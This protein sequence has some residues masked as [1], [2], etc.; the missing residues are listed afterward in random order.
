M[1]TEQSP[2]TNVDFKQIILDLRRDLLVTFPEL[3]DNLHSDLASC[4]TDEQ[5][6]QNIYEHC[7]AIFPERFFDIL[8]QNNDIWSDNEINTTF[9]P[10]LDFAN[11]MIDENVTEQTRATV[12]KYLQLILLSITSSLNTGESFGDTAKLFEAINEDEF[13]KKLEDT[14]NQMHDMFENVTNTDESETSDTDN[15]SDDR[16]GPKINLDNLP[17]PEELHSHITGML[18]GKLGRLAR[19]IAEETAQNLDIDMEGSEDAGDVFKKLFQNP[20]KL[21]N[22]VKDVGYKLDEKIKSGDISE[23]ELLE[24]AGEIMNKMKDMP[25][26]PGMDNI[27]DLLK[28]MGMPGDPSKAFNSKAF[29]SHMEQ[30]MRMAKMKER[31]RKKQQAQAQAQA[32]TQ[33]QSSRWSDGSQMPKTSLEEAQ[34]NAEEAARQLLEAEDNENDTVSRQQKK[35]KGRKKNKKKNRKR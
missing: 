28:N 21:M 20:G 27:K 15:A 33:A 29:K 26:M 23:S 9:L 3:C 32:Q 11:L 19:D 17:N 8:Y 34:R 13:K 6:V 5:S 24:E 12:W 16:P 14:V 7:K 25:G 31:M 10:G 1:E 4:E 18:D 30:N 35:S 2:D 22:L